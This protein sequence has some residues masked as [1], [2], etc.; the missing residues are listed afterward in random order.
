[1]N[2]SIQKCDLDA[3]GHPSYPGNYPPAH[4]V[5]YCEKILFDLEEMQETERKIRLLIG[6]ADNMFRLGVS[7][8]GIAIRNKVTA[9]IF[10]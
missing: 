1:M 6:L 5:D 9:N 8:G 2:V 4:L 10:S 7:K 3:L